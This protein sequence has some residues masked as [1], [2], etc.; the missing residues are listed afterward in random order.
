MKL[1]KLIGLSAFLQATTA[2]EINSNYNDTHDELITVL[3]T[4]F[5]DSSLIDSI[6]SSMDAV[7]EIYHKQPYVMF[8]LGKIF[9]EK[10]KQ[11][12]EEEGVP[13]EEH[14]QQIVDGLNFAIER[15]PISMYRDALF[16]IR[17]VPKDLIDKIVKKLFEEHNFEASRTPTFPRVEAILR[18][19]SNVFVLL[20]ALMDTCGGTSAQICQLFI[21]VVLVALLIWVNSLIGIILGIDGTNNILDLF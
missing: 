18:G 21:F 13:E 2:N 17:K 16:A 6:D 5:E 4:H 8:P 15:T 19:T 10:I 20:A 9:Q 12:H 14:L 3:K 11:I 7:Y 1:S